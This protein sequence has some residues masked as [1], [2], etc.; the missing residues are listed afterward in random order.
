MRRPLGKEHRITSAFGPRIHPIT[1][2]K[3]NHNGTD[4]DVA[5]GNNVFA[6]AVGKVVESKLSKAPGG[7][8]GEFITIQHAGYKSRYAHM[9]SGSRKFE[10]GDKVAEGAIIGLTGTTGASTGPHLHFEIIKGGSFID[11]EAFLDKNKAEYPAKKAPEAPVAPKKETEV[12]T[13]TVKPKV[14]KKAPV[15]SEGVADA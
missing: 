5:V 6:V 12:P 9:T 10:V 13:A 11:P 2:K 8:Y 3:K 7:G 4:Y 15:A 14:A 1:K